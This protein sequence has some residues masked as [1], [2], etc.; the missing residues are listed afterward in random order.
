MQAFGRSVKLQLQAKLIQWPT[1]DGKNCT[2]NW[3]ENCNT[4]NFPVL[5]LVFFNVASCTI[6]YTQNENVKQSMTNVSIEPYTIAR[7]NRGCFI[8]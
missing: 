8:E 5:C 3:F 2:V 7:Y 4:Q 6:P 1:V